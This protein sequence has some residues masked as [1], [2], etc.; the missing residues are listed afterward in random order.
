MEGLNQ[1]I[2]ARFYVISWVLVEHKIW[3]LL[4]QSRSWKYT[5]GKFCSR[6]IF[7]NLP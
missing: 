2:G 3:T 6:R 1:I 4:K 5:T 7:R